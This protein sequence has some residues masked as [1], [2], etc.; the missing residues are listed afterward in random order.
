MLHRLICS[1]SRHKIK[2]VELMNN[3]KIMLKKRRVLKVVP[4][5]AVKKTDY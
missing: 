5:V 2:W 4:I 3:D 1:V